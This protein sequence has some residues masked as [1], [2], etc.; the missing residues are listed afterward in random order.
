MS[1]PLIRFVR[2]AAVAFVLFVVRAIKQAKFFFT[3]QQNPK[4]PRLN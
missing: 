2:V 4:K 1:I 3:Q